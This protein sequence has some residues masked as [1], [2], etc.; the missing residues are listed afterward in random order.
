[1]QQ[2]MKKQKTVDDKK[3]EDR[4]LRPRSFI[5]CV[6]LAIVSLLAAGVCLASWFVLMPEARDREPDAG[7]NESDTGA[8]LLDVQSAEASRGSTWLTLACDD[9]DSNSSQSLTGM[10]A[11]FL[12]ET[13]LRAMNSSVAACPIRR[14]NE[15]MDTFA[16]IQQDLRRAPA[17][18]ADPELP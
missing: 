4:E 13:C 16:G 17:L 11:F 10:G 6:S 9:L 15:F 18:F 2:V 5:G 12:N 14:A 8:V 1:M 3:S 7:S